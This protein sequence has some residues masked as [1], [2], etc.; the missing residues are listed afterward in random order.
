MAEGMGL[1]VVTGASS[2]IGF[3][4]ARC[5]AEAG[6]D[7]VIAADEEAIVTAAEELA[8]LGVSVT[9]VTADLATPEGVERLYTATE[10]RAVELLLANAG[11]GLGHAFLDQE[12]ADIRRVIDT[13]ITGTMLLVHRI[14][15]DMRSRD[16]GRILLTGS[17]AGFMPGSFQAVYNASKAFIDSFSWALRNELQDSEVTVTC[18]MPGPTDTA[19]FDRADMEDTKV[20]ADP[21]KA[22]PAS[23]AKT[24]F[25]AMMKGEAGVVSGFSNKIQA[26]MA[27]LLPAGM[28]AEQHRKM[29][30]PG[31]AE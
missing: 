6:Y 24:G 31:T 20:G 9:P 11:R 14:G 22:D 27:H 25:E 18:L 17:I 2:G 1:A 16:R 13:N 21:D 19:F 8:G 26:A 28:L 23:V 10:G 29:A 5:C 30:A 7:L 4:L 15:R 3:E 12:V